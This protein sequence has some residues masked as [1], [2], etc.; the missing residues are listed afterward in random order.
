MNAE[1]VRAGELAEPPALPAEGV[2]VMPVSAA[3]AE[4]EPGALDV[5]LE[6]SGEAGDESP[7]AGEA[8][9]DAAD[10]ADA[11]SSG[12]GDAGRPAARRSVD[13]AL[14]AEHVPSCWP[15]WSAT[16]DGLTT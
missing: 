14:E 13:T 4:R 5:G 3:E 1:A 8:G 16:S 12:G 2:W 6:A 9:A 7:A 15:A 11:A 10:A